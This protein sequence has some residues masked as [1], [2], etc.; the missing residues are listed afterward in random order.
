MR[1][2]DG[3][4]RSISTLAEGLELSR[5]GITKHLS[6]LE[7]AGIVVSQSVGREHQFSLNVRSVDDLRSYLESISAEWDKALLRLRDLVEK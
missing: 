5:Q 6:V 2:N 1:L 4:P 3:Q 7:G